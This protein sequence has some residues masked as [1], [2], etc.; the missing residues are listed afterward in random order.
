MQL[1]GTTSFYLNH[2]TNTD[3]ID[4]FRLSD[5]RKDMDL[6]LVSAWWVQELITTA[7]VL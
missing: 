4:A 6:L 2:S 1:K 7:F 3:R 5:H